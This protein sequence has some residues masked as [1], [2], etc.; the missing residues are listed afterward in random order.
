MDRSVIKS[1]V[2]TVDVTDQLSDLGL[3]VRSFRKSWGSNLNKDDLASPFGVNLQEL[4]KRLELVV[5]SLGN[6]EL[7]SSD[8]DLLALVKRTKGIGLGINTRSV[9][10]RKWKKNQ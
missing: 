10:S 6:V 2:S 3:E 9:T 4:F 5:D 8:N 1:T 7:L